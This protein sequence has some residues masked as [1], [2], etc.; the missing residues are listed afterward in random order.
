MNTFSRS[1]VLGALILSTAACAQRSA[2]IAPAYS[3]RSI[4]DPLSCPQIRAETDAVVARLNNLS[5]V[6]DRKATTDAV[7][8]GVGIVLFWPALIF[9]S[10]VSGSDNAPEI[11]NLKGQAESLQIAYRAKNC[12]AGA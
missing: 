4:Y 1:V 3:S 5:G 9:T 11:A 7:L 10:G 12:A 6:Q 8:T 2:D